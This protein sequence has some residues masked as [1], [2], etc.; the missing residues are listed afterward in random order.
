MK[1]IE[2]MANNS[3]EENILEAFLDAGV[4]KYYTKY[5]SVHGVGR[6]G[7]KMGDSVWPEENFTL[8]IWCD[9]DEARMIHDALAKVKERF[10]DEGIKMFGLD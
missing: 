7:P 9:E 5:N 10:P 4:G 8:V 2:I 1:R 3:V 6:S